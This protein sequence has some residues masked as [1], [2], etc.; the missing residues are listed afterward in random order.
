VRGWSLALA[1]ILWAYLLLV[2]PWLAHRSHRLLV[3]LLAAG[4]IR[5]YTS[6][7]ARNVAITAVAV[8]LVVT[9]NGVAPDGDT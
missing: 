1:L 8:A 3:K 6:S 5:Q 4:R 9:A 7:A 2:A